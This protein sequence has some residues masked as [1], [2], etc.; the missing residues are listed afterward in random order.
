VREVELVRRVGDVEGF[1]ERAYV[2]T[3]PEGTGS[4]WSFKCSE[5]SYAGSLQR[6]E[7]LGRTAGGGGNESRVLDGGGQGRRG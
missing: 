7:R 2:A 4:L 5:V 6:R 1:C 3:R